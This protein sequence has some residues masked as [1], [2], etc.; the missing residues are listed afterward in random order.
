VLIACW[1][2]KGGSGTT[3]VAASLAAA[4][5]RSQPGG[6]VLADL[7]G[8]GPAVLGLGDA[9]TLGVGDW[10]AAGDD[11][12][13]DGLTR[14]EVEIVHGLRLLPRGRPLDDAAAPRH[15]A[16]SASLAADTRPVVADCGLASA[17]AA[18]ALASSAPT[19]LAVLRPCYL[20]LRRAADAPLRATAIVLV[21]EA[22]RALGASDVEAV[23]GVPVRA[24]VAYSPEVARAVDAGLLVQ[25][26]PRRLARSLRGAA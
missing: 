26:L 17:G 2:P 23:L 9:P 1:S 13:V 3:V 20:A 5:A 25:R 8:D 22:G 14:L 10:L 6:A 11:V 15:E 4:L 12:P 18:R 16:L 24:R 19:S 7:C 21:E